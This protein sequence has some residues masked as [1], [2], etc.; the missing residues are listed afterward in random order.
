MDSESYSDY[1]GKASGGSV[2]YSKILRTRV[3]RSL[4]GCPASLTRRCPMARYGKPGC[5]GGKK[6]R[7]KGKGRGLGK[8]KGKGPMRRRRR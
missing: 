4:R 7:S 1:R 8:G 3:P 6:V 2:P 5:P